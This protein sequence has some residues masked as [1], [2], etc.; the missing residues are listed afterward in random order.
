MSEMMSS[1][2]LGRADLEQGEDHRGT[3]LRCVC[4]SGL[5]SRN[6]I[7]AWG[8]ACP[9]CCSETQSEAR[10]VSPT[11]VVRRTLALILALRAPVAVGGC[12]QVDGGAIEASWVLRTFDGRA[13]SGCGCADPAIAR[14]RFVVRPDRGR[15]A[16]SGQDVCAGQA[17]CEFSCRSQRGATPFFVPAG[18]YA[19]SVAPLDVGGHA[20]GAAAPRRR[21]RPGAGTDLARR[22]LRTAHPA[23]CRRHRNR[24]CADLQRRPQQQGCAGN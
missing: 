11:I 9:R 24:V 17:G 19:I 6:V 10:M 3:P 4:W 15:R 8:P 14:V 5:G 22:R 7:D 12:V 2:L 13:I 18:R 21:R 16:R 23:R 20:A 1:L